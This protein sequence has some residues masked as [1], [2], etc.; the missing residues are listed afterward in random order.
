[1]FVAETRADG[2]HNLELGRNKLAQDVRALIVDIVNFFLTSETGHA[3]LSKS[4][5]PCDEAIG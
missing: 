4:K 1:M 5:E 2:G 3:N